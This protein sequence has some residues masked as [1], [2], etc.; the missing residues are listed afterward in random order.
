MFCAEIFK[1]K[2]RFFLSENFYFLEVK[3]S[4]YL[5]RRVFVMDKKNM[6]DAT[7]AYPALLYGSY[8]QDTGWIKFSAHGILKYFS[9]F[10]RKQDLTFH[11]NFLQWR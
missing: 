9:Y 7:V 6:A 10:P 2:I 11:A 4:V 8:K 3:F 5:N 1:K